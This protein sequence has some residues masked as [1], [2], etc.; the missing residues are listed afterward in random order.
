[1]AIR[2]GTNGAN[3]LN[4]TNSSDII[5]AFGGDD[6]ILAGGGNDLVFAGAGNDQIFAGDGSDIV[7]AGIG[8]D[9]VSG[10]N[11]SDFLYGEAGNDVLDGG[12]G[13]DIVDGGSGNDTLIFTDSERGGLDRYIGGSGQDSLVLEFTAAR[14]ADPAVKAQILAYLDFLAAGN[15]GN[16]NLTAMSLIVG[17]VEA[18]VVKVDGVIIDP[19][20][21]GNTAPTGVADAYSTGE[22]GILTV[23]P[24][25]E[26]GTLVDNDNTGNGAFTVELVTGPA[27]GALTLNADGTF[28]FNPGAAFDSLAAGQSTTETFT[29]RVVNSAGTSQPITVTLNIAGANDAAVISG[30]L[31]GAVTEDVYDEGSQD[32]V[33]SISGQVLVADA[34]TGQAAT[35]NPGTYNGQYGTLVLNTD[36]SWVYTLDATAPPVQGLG[37]GDQATDV[38]NVTSVDG[39]ASEAITITINGTNDLAIAFGET[40]GTVEEDGGSPEN[41]SGTSV[42]TGTLTIFDLDEDESGIPGPVSTLG[43]YGSFEMDA[44][45]AW[46]YE[47][48]NQSPEVQA[49][50]A[51]EIMMDVIGFQSIDGSNV[52]LTIQITGTNDIP[53]VQGILDGSVNE[54]GSSF[55]NESGTLTA[56]GEFTVNDID[57]GESGFVGAGVIE[58][59]YGTLDLAANGEW[60]YTLDSERAVVQALRG[61]QIVTEVFEIETIDG[62]PLDISINIQGENDEAF[63]DGQLSGTI[64]LQYEQ[65]SASGSIFVDDVDTDESGVFAFLGE[66]AI[67]GEFGSLEI[68]EDGDW[69]YQ[70]YNDG[71]FLGESQIVSDDFT[72]STLGGDEFVI[73]ITIV[74]Q[75]I[76]PS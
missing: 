16:F 54:D 56:T 12:R 65:S 13:S 58:G 24:A 38:F 64:I 74:D 26:R 73:N 8:N 68:T 49:L 33:V 21:G 23:S 42:A 70:L 44:A 51:G 3:T 25:T 71:V 50:R 11:G 20:A 1:M 5:L 76:F 57:T 10:G 46:T 48:N 6:L 39:T 19:R 37:E 53:D 66:S 72:L 47:L 69:S 59:T 43:L 60:T 28:S 63:I 18:L 32:S 31:A 17:S 29:Y 9:V 62:T 52:F 67:Q 40:F 2:I 27:R 36:G 55:F 75:D 61:D 35:A 7:F 22:N 41:E 45:G 34:D 14:W 30:D 4:G 15:Q